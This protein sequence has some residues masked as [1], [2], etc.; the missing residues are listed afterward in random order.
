MCLTRTK[1]SPRIRFICI[2]KWFQKV[3]KQNQGYRD[4]DASKINVWFFGHPL[5]S[6]FW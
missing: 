6:E 2:I 1:A 5:E 3:K 4:A